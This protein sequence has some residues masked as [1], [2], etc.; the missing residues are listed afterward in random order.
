V[1]QV[2]A[3]PSKHAGSELGHDTYLLSSTAS[4]CCTVMGVIGAN[5]GTWQE[6]Q[7]NVPLQAVQRLPQLL[8]VDPK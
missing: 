8:S 4:E 2:F 5:L 6:R 1:F 3:E 7:L